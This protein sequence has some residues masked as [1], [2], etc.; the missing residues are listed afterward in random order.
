MNYWLM[1][2]EPSAFSIDDLAKKSLQT[3]HWDGVRNYQARNMLR[4]QM[5]VGDQAF[6]YHSSCEVPGI[7][8]VVEIV[9]SAYP[10]PSALNPN[11]KYF[12]SRSTAENPRWFMVDVKLIKKFHHVISLKELAHIPALSNMQVLRKGN[13]LSIMP[14]TIKEWHTILDLAQ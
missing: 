11:S 12:D 14:V 7:V 1:K 10:D 8:G 2:T 3:E 4:D 6:F 9:K 5:Q 13:R